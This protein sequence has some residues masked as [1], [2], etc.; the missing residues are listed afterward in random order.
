MKVLIVLT[1]H[2]RLGDTGNTQVI[3]PQVLAEPVLIQTRTAA[4]RKSTISIRFRG[5][6]PGEVSLGSEFVVLDIFDHAPAVSERNL[7]R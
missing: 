5:A 6:N 7:A 1:S 3:R 4:R 2:D